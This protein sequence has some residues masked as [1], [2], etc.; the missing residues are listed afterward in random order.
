MLTVNK[1]YMLLEIET[2]E[3]IITIM[4]RN[5]YNLSENIFRIRLFFICSE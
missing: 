2:P 1:V 5:W 3:A 4:I